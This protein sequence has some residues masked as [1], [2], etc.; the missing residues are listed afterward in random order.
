MPLFG[1]GTFRI[2][3]G[4][5]TQQVVRTALEYGYRLIDT[6]SSYGNEE[7]VGRA[8][9][10][11]GIA[12]EKIFL[13]TKVWVDEQGYQ[14]TMR[15]CDRSL[16]RLH[17]DYLDLY[18][19]HWPAPGIWLD[20]WRAMIALLDQGKCRAIGV[21]NFFIHH[22]ETQHQLS[23]VPP[24]VNQVEFSPFWYRKDLLD[25]CRQ[26]SIQLEAYSSLTRGEKFDHP[27]IQKIAAK[28][29]KTPA[30]IL[31]RWPLQHEIVVIPKSTHPD[32]IRDN[33]D[34][35]DFEIAP[36]DMTV[37]DNLNEDFSLVSSSWRMQFR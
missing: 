21:S 2:P 27:V 1:F 30:Q 34:V 7:D 31:L 15:A 9:I 33:A 11:S 6:A 3:Q 32:R 4:S 19:I 37:L 29:G 10:D 20:S 5:V 18:L 24:A 22:L 16:R 36:E 26:H 8:L 28:Y 25:Y 14:E 17:T 12:R 23:S 35:F 13:T